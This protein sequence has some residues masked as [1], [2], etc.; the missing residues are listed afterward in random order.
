MNPDR[1]PAERRPGRTV[2]LVAAVVEVAFAV[3]LGFLRAH[4]S[5]VGAWRAE[6]VLPTLA[7]TAL[8]AAPGIL[9][10]VGV[11]IDRP[12]L[13]GVAG[14]GCLPV[15]IISIAAFPILI[16][17]VVRLI[18]FA[19]SMFTQPAALA[20]TLAVFAVFIGLVVVALGIMLGE[21]GTYSYTYAAGGAEGGEYYLPASAAV[22][23]ALVAVAL[24]VT[25][26]IAARF[27]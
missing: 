19:L 1:V 18:A 22:V 14:A 3:G 8:F 9:A 15:A 20:P 25:T 5:S 10:L 27:E 4:N 21:K 17:A 24:T 11:M 23:L 16:P 12:V 6:G 13:W 7:L 2:A 26:V